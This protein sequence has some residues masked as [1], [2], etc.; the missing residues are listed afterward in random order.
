MMGDG[1]ALGST[2]SAQK[3]DMVGTGG[4]GLAATAQAPRMEEEAKAKMHPLAL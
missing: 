1:A 3:S 4:T 2:V